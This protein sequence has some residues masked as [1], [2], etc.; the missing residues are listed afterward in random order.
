MIPAD[1]ALIQLL[2]AR[3]FDPLIRELINHICFAKYLLFL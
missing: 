3:M 2:N 1:F